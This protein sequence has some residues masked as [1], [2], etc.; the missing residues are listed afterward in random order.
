MIVEC[1]I[2]NHQTAELALNFKN[3]VIDDYLYSDDNRFS[4]G[5]HRASDSDDVATYSRRKRETSLDCRSGQRYD[6]QWSVKDQ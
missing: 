2:R 5:R 4:L 6:C 1:L 3:I